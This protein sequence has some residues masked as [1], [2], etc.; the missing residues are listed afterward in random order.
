MPKCKC[1]K[2]GIFNSPEDAQQFIDKHPH[3]HN[4][5]LCFKVDPPKYH[6]TS[7]RVTTSQLNP[8]ERRGTMA[9]SAKSLIVKAM[10]R[11]YRENNEVKFT[12]Q[13]IGRAIK[14][15][16]GRDFTVPGIRQGVY[17][18]VKDDVVVDLKE[19]TNGK[20]PSKYFALSEV[21]NAET[22][23]NAPTSIK[24]GSSPVNLPVAKNE[25]NEVIVNQLSGLARG[26]REHTEK[27]NEFLGQLPTKE[28]LREL[29]ATR[30]LEDNSENYLKGYKDGIKEGIKL[31]KEMGL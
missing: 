18:L 21:L 3:L 31:A 26:Y 22:S 11:R 24:E 29:V 28:V 20:H 16:F 25:D 5:Y 9:E 4:Y 7:L 30:P 6:V 23:P 19:T 12:V 14:Q 1:G 2:K 27:L 17:R 10:R 15:D 13:D 8:I